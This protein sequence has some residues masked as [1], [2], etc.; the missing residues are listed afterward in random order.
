MTVL[1]APKVDE[2]LATFHLVALAGLRVLAA[3]E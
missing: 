1:A 3:G 2:V